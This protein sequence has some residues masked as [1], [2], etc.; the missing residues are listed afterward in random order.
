MMQIFDKLKTFF[1][2]RLADPA[3]WPVA[4]L[5]V[6]KWQGRM[7]WDKA[8]ATGKVNF[9]MI[10]AGAGNADLDVQWPRNR[11]ELSRLG[12]PYGFY[13]AVIPRNATNW[14]QHLDSIGKAFQATPDAR[15]GVWLDIE[16]NPEKMGKTA[17]EGW[18][19]KLVDSLQQATVRPPGIYTGAWFWDNNLPLTNWAKHLALWIAQYNANIIVPSL[20]NDWTPK[21]NP[22]GFPYTFWQWSADKNGQGPAFGA[23]SADIDLN[24]FNGGPLDFELRFKVKPYFPAAA[25]P[26]PPQAQPFQVR[27]TSAYVNLR[28]AAQSTS[29]DLGDLRQGSVIT[30]MDAPGDYYQTVTGYIYKAGVERV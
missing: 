9:A 26:P 18:V 25:P 6:S 27:V 23:Q 24:R 21:N 11:D 22:A 10:R 16:Q 30:V 8:A 3:L 13:W 1:S 4:G 19:S 7:D 12:I 5:D 29:A 17:F 14:K 2:P 15:L 20:P 28:E